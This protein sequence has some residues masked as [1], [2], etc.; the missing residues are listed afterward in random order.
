MGYILRFTGRKNAI[1][2]GLV[3]LSVAFILAIFCSFIQTQFLF[4]V[5]YC[6][7]RFIHGASQAFVQVTTY[8][9][10]AACFKDH[11]AKV[12]GIVEFSWGTGIALGPLIAEVLYNIGGFNLP[13]FVFAILML[14][15]AVMTALLM[16]NS[17]EGED[18]RDVDMMQHTDSSI[19]ARD[20]SIEEHSVELKEKIPISRLFK[21]KLFV[22]GIFAGF[23]NLV[24]YTL[25]EP[26]LSDRL[27]EIGVP[28]EKLGQYF[29]IQPFVYSF[30]SIFV[31]GL[32]LK[33]IHKRV[34]L[35]IG[36]AIFA[37]GFII[38]GPSGLLFFLEPSKLL[39]CFG[40][41][42]LGIGC[43]LSFVPIFPELIES[44]VF[45]FEDRIE[46]LNNTVASLM[47][48]S[49]GSAALG[50]L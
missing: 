19:D 17:V 24:L 15:L 9:I 18:V 3:M 1:L 42:I 2:F 13:L 45:D 43:S 31:D 29:C 23:F 47:N 46:D 36:F 14:L 48:A 27:T 50:Q 30:V 11:I 6:V 41:F 10:I 33:K 25:L 5:C 21:Y 22:F 35:I 20:T 44:V 38:L 4:V 37:V 40:L 28:E 26:I 12:V 39:A 34:C 16:S 32:I 49:Y 8:S 7:V